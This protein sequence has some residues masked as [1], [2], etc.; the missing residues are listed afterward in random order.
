[1]KDIC[2]YCN[3][4]IEY[5]NG[6]QFGA[7]LTNCLEN[8]SKKERDLKQKR[9]TDFELSCSKCGISYLVNITKHH[10][11]IGRYNKF[12]SRSCANKRNHTKETKEKISLGLSKGIKLYTKKCEKC[13]CSFNTRKDNQKFCSRK[14]QANIV[15]T[16]EKGKKGGL[17]SVKSQ[18]RRSKNEVTFGNLC[19]KIFNKVIFNEPVFNGWDADIIIE[20]LKIAIL[21]NSI[22]HYKKVFE[23]HSLSKVQN[24]DKIKIEEIKRC[25]YI[26][27]IIKDMGGYNLDKVNLEWEIFNI[28]LNNRHILIE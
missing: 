9:K 26:P 12:C 27:Y 24:R 25:G 20:D 6:K 16:S 7:H 11:D 1:M 3:K 18:N 23:K 13:S 14:C 10:Y 2:K 15:N 19:Q 4:E 28:W 5:E 21:W 22:W 17:K 8:P